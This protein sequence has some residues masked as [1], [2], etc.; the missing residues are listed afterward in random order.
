M[1][2]LARSWNL[3]RGLPG[4][5]DSTMQPS[6]PQV[7]SQGQATSKEQA[8][9]LH[10][11]L[12]VTLWRQLRWPELTSLIFW[13]GI[14]FLGGRQTHLPFDPSSARRRTPST[15]QL[16]VPGRNAPYRLRTH[17][18]AMP[19][20]QR[21]EKPTCHRCQPTLVLFPCSQ[22]LSGAALN[23]IAWPLGR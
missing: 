11:T 15:L 4:F 22:A 6:D 23:G 1:A 18:A 7:L 12:E 8:R 21:R 16:M 17:R 10:H 5:K 3:N 19:P 20:P 13:L 2:S 9:R 14:W